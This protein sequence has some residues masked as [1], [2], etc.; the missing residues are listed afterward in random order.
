MNLYWNV[1]RHL[2]CLKQTHQVA[3]RLNPYVT[4]TD[5]YTIVPNPE[6]ADKIEAVKKLLY[7][8]VDNRHDIEDTE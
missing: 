6:L 8:E 5:D 3:S 7:G 2:T 1:V 4:I